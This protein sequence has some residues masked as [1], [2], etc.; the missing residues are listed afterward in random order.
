MLVGTGVLVLSLSVATASANQSSYDFHAGDGFAGIA[1][2]DVSAAPNG[3]TIT[4]N[5]KGTFRIDGHKASGGGTFVHKA[6]NG[7]VLARG[8]FEVER[9]T[10]FD[11]FGCGVAAGQPFPPDFCGGRA[12]MPVEIDGHAASGGKEEFDGVLTI[13]CLVGD[14]VP[15]GAQELDALKIPGVIDFNR[16]VSGENL[17]VKENGNKHEQDDENREERHSEHD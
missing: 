10:S 16:P 15:P 14:R 8:T 12:V 7:T 3:D 2:P 6:A 1:S 5:A 9:L 17:F 11:P 13:T 4:I